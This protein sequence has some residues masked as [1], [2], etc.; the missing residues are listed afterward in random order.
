MNEMIYKPDV[1]INNP[2]YLLRQAEEL[3]KIAKSNENVSSLIYASLECR[4]ALELMEL[5]FLLHSVKREE[6]EQI[7]DDSKPKNGIDR[8]NNKVGSLKFKYQQFL[9]AVCE[10]LDIDNEF[11][12]YKKSKNLQHELSTYIHSYYLINVEIK[13]QSAYMQKCLELI[14]KVINF[15]KSSMPYKDGTYTMLGM[16]IASMP[17]EDRIILDEW[18]TSTKMTYEELK[19]MLK[20]NHN[21]RKQKE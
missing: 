15:V 21:K 3:I 8:V 12:D 5:N 17:V 6:R 1:R 18:K 4:I 7:I 14:L 19:E 10:I 2:I 11:Y 20:S 16:E 9:Q 13:Y